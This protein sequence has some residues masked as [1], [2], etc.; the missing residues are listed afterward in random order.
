[1]RVVC[2]IIYIFIY[3]LGILKRIVHNSWLQ[4]K[5]SIK[6]DISAKI[7]Y[8]NIK[9]V[10][11][12][13]GTIIDSS[14]VIFCTDDIKSNNPR[15]KLI[16]GKNTYIGE[17]NNIRCA[18]EKIIIGDD[19]LIS[20]NVNIIGS[21]HSAKK[22]ILIN[23]QKWSNDKTGVIIGNDVWIGCGATILPGV[24]IGNG[25]I[26]AAGSL[27]NN[28]VAENTIVAGMPAKYIKDRE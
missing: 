12:G 2:F 28:D 1:M 4:A 17:M 8:D 3:C 26:I 25:A 5:F 24:S 21:N 13:A 18:N 7:N 11:I 27:V 9:Q 15:A 19:C 22:N 14:T 16:I 10:E 20:Q 23:K 6:L